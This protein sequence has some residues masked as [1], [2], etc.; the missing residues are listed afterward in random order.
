MESFVLN[1]PSAM[2]VVASAVV[3]TVGVLKIMASGK[4]TRSLDELHNDHKTLLDR[5]QGVETQMVRLEADLEGTITTQ[6]KDLKEDVLRIDGKIDSLVKEV[7]S[8]LASIIK[9]D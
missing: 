5:V 8:A 4:A 6:I 7:V 2:A 9:K 3:L 1:W